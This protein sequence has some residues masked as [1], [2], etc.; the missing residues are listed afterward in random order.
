MGEQ[1]GY[2]RQTSALDVG[3]VAPI[4]LIAPCVQRR[5]AF[6]KVVWIIK[7]STFVATKNGQANIA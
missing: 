7:L 6:N 1:R 3:K 4:Y 5:A 2:S